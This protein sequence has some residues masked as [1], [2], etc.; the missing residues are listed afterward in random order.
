MQ[1]WYLFKVTASEKIPLQQRKDANK[2][3][4]G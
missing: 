1:I 3:A 4:Q 2:H